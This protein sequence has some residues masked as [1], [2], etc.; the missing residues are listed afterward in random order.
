M[1]NSYCSLYIHKLNEKN[2]Y[3]QKCS[4]FIPESKLY[5]EKKTL[6]RLRCNC[7]HGLVRHKTRI[8]KINIKP[9]PTL[10]NLQPNS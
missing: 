3:C 7:C 2:H 5:K 6:G 10:N 8:Y 9:S 1:C 4:T